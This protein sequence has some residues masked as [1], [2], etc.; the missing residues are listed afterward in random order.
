MHD[1]CVYS[2]MMPS[3]LWCVKHDV[4]HVLI[5]DLRCEGGSQDTP[6]AAVLQMLGRIPFVSC[7]DFCKPTAP[8]HIHKP[9]TLPS[10]AN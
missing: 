3:L 10:T 4:G 5:S 9:D 7:L 2:A 6:G 1:G 8:A